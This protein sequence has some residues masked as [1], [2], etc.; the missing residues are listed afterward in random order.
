ALAIDEKIGYPEYLGSTNTLELD[1]MYQEYVFNTSY[2]NNILKL[3][4]IKSNESIRM[5]RD[6]VD[7]KAWGPSP[8]TTVNAFYNPPT[9]QISKENIFEI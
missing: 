6:P 3:L 4:T 7:R 8:P 2:I 1:K 5:L 9:N